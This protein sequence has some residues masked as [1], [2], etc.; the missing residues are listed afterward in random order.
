MPHISEVRG[1]KKPPQRRV[2]LP[3]DDSK[4]DRYNKTV[5][6]HDRAV[7]KQ[8][9]SNDPADHRRVKE[10]AAQLAEV[11]QQ[12]EDDEIE[13]VFQAMPRNRYSDLLEEH[14]PSDED[15]EAG[16]AFNADT[17][18]PALIAECLIEPE[19]VDVQEATRIWAEWSDAECEMLLANA[20]AVNRSLKDIPFTKSDTG[21]TASSDVS[22]TIAPI[23]ESLT[24]GS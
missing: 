14:P 10:L 15:K 20:I 3:A 13:F 5:K 11:R 7:R 22:S 4:V 12:I 24:V 2:R 6:D 16:L 23:G 21:E 18:P 8:G 1:R 19:G 9:M 17:F